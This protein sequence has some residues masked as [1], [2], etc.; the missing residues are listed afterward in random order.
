MLE[1][2]GACCSRDLPHHTTRIFELCL[3]LNNGGRQCDLP[4]IEVVECSLHVTDGD[5]VRC[6]RTSVY[7]AQT[8]VIVYRGEE[9]MIFLGSSMYNVL[10]GVSLSVCWSVCVETLCML[11][12]LSA[13]RLWAFWGKTFEHG[14][15][16][17]ADD[18]W[19][20]ISSCTPPFK[21]SKAG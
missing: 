5:P 4:A 20:T 2:E 12:M 1:V 13:E 11:C 9:Q 18:K 21:C 3:H 15:S 8:M 16:R 6:L 14:V 7:Y 19:L 10:A 17:L